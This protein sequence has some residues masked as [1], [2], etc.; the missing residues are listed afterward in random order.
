[1]VIMTPTPL[2]TPSPAST[3]SISSVVTPSPNRHN[4]PRSRR[5]QPFVISSPPPSPSKKKAD[6][7]VVSSP[8]HTRGYGT[9]LRS[10][11]NEKSCKEAKSFLPL[12]WIGHGARCALLD[13]PVLLCFAAVC[14][15]ALVVRL[16]DEYWT[17]QLAAETWTPGRW[18]KENTYF[19]RL[20]SPDHQTA[21]SMADP[22]IV[23]QPTDT[24][25]DAKRKMLTHGATLY[26][27]ILSPET[28][29]EVRN[30][31]V[32]QNLAGKDMIKVIGNENRYSFAIQV[33]Q[34]PS[35]PKA[36]KEVLTNQRL[37]AA[38]EEII[39]PD[40]AVIEFTGITST[41]GAEA[42]NMHAD[43]VPQ[44]SAQR[45]ARDFV[46]SY[47][48]FIPLQNTTSEMGATFVCPGTHQCYRG[49]D[50]FCDKTAVQ[51]SGP[52]NN[53]PAGW[54][55]LVNQ[56][57]LHKGSAHTDEYG[58]DRVL[59]IITFAP[60][61]RWGRQEVETRILGSG[62]SYSLHW[63]QWGHTLSDFAD[64]ERRMK[65]PFR[66]FK[67]LG[68]YKTNQ[69]KWGWDFWTLWYQRVAQEEL[70]YSRKD[71]FET[72]DTGGFDWIPKIIRGNRQAYVTTNPY[73]VEEED[74]TDDDF[75]DDDE[76]AT[77][78]WIV[79]AEAVI[80]NA[81]A[82]AVKIY[83]RSTLFF[84]GVVLLG[85]V[86][87]CMRGNRT[88]F[89]RPIRRV[90]LGHAAILLCAWLYFRS[91]EQGTLAR[92][93]RKG[94]A[95]NIKISD[96][97]HLPNLPSTLATE[98]D[99]L[100]TSEYQSQYLGSYSDLIDYTHSGNVLWRREIEASYQN[101]EG[102]SLSL[103]KE[104]CREVTLRVRQGGGRFLTK[105]KRN[106]W[107]V[108]T[109]PMAKDFCDEAMRSKADPAVGNMVKWTEYLISE[110][111]FGYWRNARSLRVLTIKQL[112][113]IQSKLLGRVGKVIKQG[114]RLATT[115]QVQPKLRSLPNLLLSTRQTR[116]KRHTLPPRPEVAE[117]YL[118]AWLQ[119][120][121]LV[122]GRYR[123]DTNEWYQ[124]KIT[125]VVFDDLDFWT[126]EYFDGDDDKFLCRSCVRPFL[127]FDAG[128]RVFWKETEIGTFLECEVLDFDSGRSTYDLKLLHDSSI[129]YGI[130]QE[131]I[132]RRTEDIGDGDDVDDY[133]TWNE[134]DRVLAYFPEDLEE[135]AFPGV[136]SRIVG[137]GFY[138][139]LYDDG[140]IAVVPHNMIVG[141][142]D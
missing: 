86:F 44:G 126:V 36:L 119:V 42:Q 100:L 99:V 50:Q 108:M 13:L 65:A 105:N 135:G 69:Q 6:G 77:S 125:A 142:F 76:N 92:N 32:K 53:W 113:S 139:I 23:F 122:E 49:G 29:S 67:S 24:A 28:A 134:G 94:L 66:Y 11:V 75:E 21:F 15:S 114:N 87:R 55:A 54:G 25:A 9:A 136:V 59:F 27:H 71:F 1:M 38:L 35:V 133:E 93:L 97:S 118:G 3:A 109:Q 2:S 91:I 140:D 31:I 56:Q 130:A 14:G 74:T 45:F 30:F 106:E 82:L 57:T 127:P 138:R 121:D 137:K 129:V 39:G 17:R 95:F 48:L 83:Q 70:G 80:E 101:Y 89:Y 128:E 40:P 64:A 34:H 46:P 16:R 116:S 104:L 88:S 131:R 98:E 60:R 22:D 107:G 124:G 18:Q 58:P 72:L 41:Y 33:D 62:G 123:G 78:V 12:Q 132:H 68:L 43:V 47:S 8:M 84:V 102:M 63:S 115:R 96:Y 20:C 79:F 37:V 90:I 19:G 120:G 73:E 85:N 52:N 112:Q 7:L 10:H 4:S 81:Y 103:Q 110:F 26:P 5:Q 111:R 141:P 51:A 117:P 61:P